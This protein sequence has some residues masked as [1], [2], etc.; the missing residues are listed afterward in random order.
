MNTTANPTLA[1]TIRPESLATPLSN[2]AV[3]LQDS[4]G[5]CEIRLLADRVPSLRAGS[6]HKVYRGWR[7]A[8]VMQQGQPRPGTTLFA[9]PVDPAQLAAS[10][11]RYALVQLATPEATV[12]GDPAAFAWSATSVG[13]ADPFATALA[14]VRRQLVAAGWMVDAVIP[15]RY[16]KAAPTIAVG[17]AIAMPPSVSAAHVAVL[18]PNPAP[19]TAGSDHLSRAAQRQ[20]IAGLDA[21]ETEGGTSQ[22]L[23]DYAAGTTSGDAGD[24]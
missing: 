19:R 14:Q 10:R 7:F 16:T 11:S 22:S 4:W 3:A 6:T 15:T 20:E 8:V 2:D 21:W 5:L 12:A 23:S 24:R 9:V 17:E 18:E 1:A 13:S